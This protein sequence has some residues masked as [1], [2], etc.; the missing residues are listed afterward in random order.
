MKY[1]PE[2]IRVLDRF[3]EP[4]V[5]TLD[6]SFRSRIR[7]KSYLLYDGI[8]SGTFAND[9]IAADVIYKTASTDPRYT[10]LKGNLKRRLL[11]SLFHLNLRRAGFSEAGQAAYFVK[12]RAFLVHTLVTLGARSAAMRL[13]ER[14]LEISTKFQFIDVAYEMALLLRTNAALYVR[15]AAYERYDT[16]VKHF[17]RLL[18]EEQIAWEYFDRVNMTLN[19]FTGGRRRFAETFATYESK[20]DALLHPESSFTFRLNF[21]RV[22]GA[23]LGVSGKHLERIQWMDDAC[24]Y[25]RSVPH[26]AQ[27]L[28]FGEFKMQQLDSYLRIGSMQKAEAVATECLDIFQVHTGGRQNFSLQEYRFLIYANT[29]RFDEATAIYFEVTGHFDF[30]SQPEV[31]LERWKIYEYYLH[32]ALIRDGKKS[33]FQHRFRID[34]LLA[35]TPASGQDKIGMNIALR[36]LQILYLLEDRRLSEIFDRME[37]LQ[38]YRARYLVAK[39]TRASSLF[40]KLMKIMENNSFAFERSKRQGMRYYMQLKTE[41][42]DVVDSEQEL[43]ILPYTWLWDRVLERL[44][45][46]EK[47]GVSA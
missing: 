19:R 12:K 46:L 16:L 37:S 28:R 33:P 31:M 29:L 47:T 20:L 22:K 15:P 4:R 34:T 32:F 6:A 40:L 39:V 35:Q 11:N 26:L 41:T 2:I 36:I 14:N 17:L 7:E 44:E 23:T 3:R 43:Q 38:Q 9:S 21:Y 30:Q 24:E 5:E 42:F 18:T 8:R 27:R 10:T 25:L 1:L 45:D 13:A